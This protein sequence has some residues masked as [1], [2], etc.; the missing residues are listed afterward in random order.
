MSGA[1]T[2]FHPISLKLISS[3]KRQH[4]VSPSPC[5]QSSRSSDRFFSSQDRSLLWVDIYG[6]WSHLVLASWCYWKVYQLTERLVMWWDL[7]AMIGWWGCPPSLALLLQR[8]S[9]PTPV[10]RAPPYENLPVCAGL[11]CHWPLARATDKCPH[12]R[13]GA[14][15]TCLWGCWDA[16]PA[17]TSWELLTARVSP[18][19]HQQVAECPPWN[20]V[21]IHPRNTKHLAGWQLAPHLQVHTISSLCNTLCLL[22]DW[23]L[24][25]CDGQ[26]FWAQGISLYSFSSQVK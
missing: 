1:R 16:R 22:C 7:K 11:P 19:G 5:T 20:R 9:S 6:R 25:V 2:Q 8:W 17:C 4:L 26:Q 24:Q 3:G 13:Y 23:T 14:A 12:E 18:A 15:G 10:C 21:G